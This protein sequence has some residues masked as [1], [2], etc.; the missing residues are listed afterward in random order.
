VGVKRRQEILRRVQQSGYVSARE[1]AEEYGVD[2]STLRRDLDALARLGLVVRNHGGASLPAE[3]PAPTDAD[4]AERLPQKRAVGQAVAR[5]VGD[6][7]S[8]ALD[9][10]PAALE[11]ARALRSCRGTTVVTNDLRVATEVAA[12]DDVRL[13]VLGGEVLPDRSTLVGDRTVDLVTGYHLDYAIVAA[14]AVGPRGVSVSDTFGA[15]LKQAMVRAATTVVVVADSSA[16]DRSALVRVAGLEDVDLV[17]TDDGLSEQD[18]A[19]CAVDVM[20]VPVPES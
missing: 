10:G 18:A 15:P 7:Q 12:Q 1:L 16:F 3:P 8:V 19:A 17:V 20:R 14:D 5:L 6:G 11:V 2:T 4:V 13:I 9:G